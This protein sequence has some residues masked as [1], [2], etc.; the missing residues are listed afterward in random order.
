MYDSKQWPGSVNYIGVM[1]K[2]DETLYRFYF[3]KIV[4]PSNIL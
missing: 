2:K 4:W 1:R 3:G